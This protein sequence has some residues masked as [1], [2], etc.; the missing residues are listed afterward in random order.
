MQNHIKPWKGPKKIIIIPSLFVSN[1]KKVNGSAGI[2]YFWNF[3]HFV[4]LGE[5]ES[6]H[7]CPEPQWWTAT[8]G[9]LLSAW[10]GELRASMKADPGKPANVYFQDGCT[11][12]GVL[13]VICLPDNQDENLLFK[14]DSGL[15]CTPSHPLALCP[16][17]VLEPAWS[18]S[19]IAQWPTFPEKVEGLSSNYIY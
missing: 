8:P 5:A 1:R 16:L 14:C 19:G 10:G 3:L 7:R 17:N 4:P 13:R 6:C 18:G 2:I 15:S 9:R 11:V 12:G